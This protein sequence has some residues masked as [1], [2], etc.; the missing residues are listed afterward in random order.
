MS[1][2]ERIARSTRAATRPKSALQLGRQ[3]AERVDVLAAREPDGAGQ[4]AADRRR[5]RSSSRPTRR[6]GVV[7][8]PQ[9]AHGGP[10]GSPRLGGS[11]TTR[12][13][14]SR[15][16]SGS[17]YGGVMVVLTM[18]P[19]LAAV[20][21]GEAVE[22]DADDAVAC[23]LRRPAVPA[24]QVDVRPGDRIEG[25]V[26]GL[27]HVAARRERPVGLALAEELDE[28]VQVVRRLARARSPDGTLRRSPASAEGAGRA[29]RRAR[30][31]RARAGRAR[32]RAWSGSG[33]SSCGSPPRAHRRA[34]RR[35][36]RASGPA[37]ERRAR[38]AGRPGRRARGSARPSRCSRSTAIVACCS[39][40]S[41]T[42]HGSA[43]LPYRSCNMH[44]ARPM[45]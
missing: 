36:P 25:D 27:D 45:R 17:R 16:I 44:V 19:F 23:P 3:V 38:A 24:A 18:A 11:G 12:S 40:W 4:A 10:P 13:P 37:P 31:A 28:R 34:S 21:G 33:T 6:A 9:M 39:S 43:P 15:W 41:T 7:S 30:P 29:A 42:A 14:G 2:S 22:H 1:P 32:S 26:C 35:A 5:A 8:P 20:C